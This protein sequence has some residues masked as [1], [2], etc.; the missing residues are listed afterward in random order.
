[1]GLIGILMETIRSIG[2]IRF[3]FSRD[4]RKLWFYGMMSARKHTLQTKIFPLLFS[5][6]FTW[7]FIYYDLKMLGYF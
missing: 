6:A 2:S 3:F 4:N 1:M 7:Y 5:T